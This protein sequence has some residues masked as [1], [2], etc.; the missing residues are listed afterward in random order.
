M[1]GCHPKG[2]RQAWKVGSYEPNEIQQ[3]QVQGVEAIPD[4]STG[5]EITE[6]R[7]AKK[8]LGILMEEKLDTS[9]QYALAAWKINNDILGCLKTGVANRVR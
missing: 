4:T 2:S 6:S 9:Q 5:W 7:S 1:K 8:D 3:D